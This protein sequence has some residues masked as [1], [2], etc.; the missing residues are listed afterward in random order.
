MRISTRIVTWTEDGTRYEGDERH[1][2]IGLEELGL[3][4]ESKSVSTPIEKEKITEEGERELDR[5][6]SRMYRGLVA[7]LY[8]LAQDRSDIQ[9]AV[10]E[11]GGDISKPTLAGTRQINKL[12]G[13]LKGVPRVDYKYGYRKQRE[14]EPPSPEPER[15]RETGVTL[16]THRRRRGPEREGTRETPQATVRAPQNRR[17][18]TRFDHHVDLV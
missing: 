6:E 9:Y 7:R 4:E 18:A 13:Y 11:I 2:E 10:E 17:T 16:E 14:E 3:W 1:A 8:Y 5:E 15:D 12:A